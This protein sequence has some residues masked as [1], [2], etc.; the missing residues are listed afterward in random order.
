MSVL[1][2][3]YQELHCFDRA[4]VSV[5]TEECGVLLRA[6]VWGTRAGSHAPQPR[7][8]VWGTRAVS[9]APQPCSRREASQDGGTDFAA[10]LCTALY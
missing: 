1:V 7:S 6:L 2:L 8:L 4:E 9:H 5:H 10:A 3:S